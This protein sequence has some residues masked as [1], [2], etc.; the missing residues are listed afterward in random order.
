MTRFTLKDVLIGLAIASVGLGM[1]AF[2]IHWRMP[3][4]SEWEGVQIG[5][6]GGGASITGIG[7]THPFMKQTKTGLAFVLRFVV[8]TAIIFAVMYAIKLQKEIP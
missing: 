5:L 1:I 4:L 6:A 2:A 3:L 7:I 8:C